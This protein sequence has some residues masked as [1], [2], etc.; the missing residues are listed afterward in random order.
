MPRHIVDAPFALSIG[1]LAFRVSPESHLVFPDSTGAYTEFILPANSQAS[2]S[3][4]LDCGIAVSIRTTD[5]PDVSSMTVLFDAD[6]AWSLREGP[7]GTFF[8]G[9][10]PASVVGPPWAFAIRSSDA[11]TVYGNRQITD[12]EGDV[13]CP[14]NYPVDQLLVVNILA[15]RAGMLVHCAG[16]RIGGK[17]YLFV[18]RS[19]AGKST[20]SNCI[21]DCQGVEVLSD[22]RMILRRKCEETVAYGTPWPGDAGFAR[23][24]SGSL[25]GIFFLEHGKENQMV[26]LSVQESVERLMQVVSVP[27]YDEVKSGQVMQL[28]GEVAQNIACQ[29]LRFKPDA[30]LWPF[31]EACIGKGSDL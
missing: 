5:V 22:D 25:A 29:S 19:G 30:N 11:A 7:D 2:N 21:A 23:N 10:G 28:I 16:M 4:D 31:I 27:W 8:V 6:D 15:D 20:I 18:G 3:S 13:V 14:M 1:G 26:P 9:H 12:E 17:I 24:E